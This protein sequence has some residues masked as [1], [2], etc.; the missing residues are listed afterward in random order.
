MRAFRFLL[1]PVLVCIVAGC[2]SNTTGVTGNNAPPP[3]PTA[4]DID[5]TV[6]ASLKTT[7]AFS[8]PQKNLSLGGAASVAVRWINE[9]ISGNDY[10]TGSAVTHQ[11]ASTD[12]PAAF[13]MSQPLGGNATYTINLSAPG[14]YNYHCNI[15]PNMVGTITV[16]P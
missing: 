8:P 1:R 4:N 3:T 11:I 16:T 5:I 15:H 7:T 2:S 14:T 12:N 13:T 10:Q 9:D 6:G